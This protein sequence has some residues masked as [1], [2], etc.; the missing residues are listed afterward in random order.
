MSDETI[1]HRH[2]THRHSAGGGRGG[3]GRFPG[4]VR[5]LAKMRPGSSQ[6]AGVLTTAVE[7]RAAPSAGGGF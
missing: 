3:D 6:R 2:G 7:P 1:S 4:V 5:T